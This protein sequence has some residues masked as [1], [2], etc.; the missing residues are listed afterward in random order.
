MEQ[1]VPKGELNL[2]DCYPLDY[3]D[4]IEVHSIRLLYNLLTSSSTRYVIMNNHSVPN[5]WVDCHIYGP[6]TD[7]VNSHQSERQGCLSAHFKL[8]KVDIHDDI[9][10]LTKEERGILTEKLRKLRKGGSS[11]QLLCDALKL[12][13]VK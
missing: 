1:R 13:R 2:W 6:I 9:L 4:Q 3:A 12:E 8:R 11:M 5:G 10:G 7:D